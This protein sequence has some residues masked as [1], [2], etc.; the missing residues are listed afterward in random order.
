MKCLSTP[1]SCMILWIISISVTLTLP[2]DSY[3]LKL[4][5]SEKFRLKPHKLSFIAD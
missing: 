3:L 2:F 1:T 5:L 4:N